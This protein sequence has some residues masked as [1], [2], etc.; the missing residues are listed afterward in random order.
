MIS[1]KT[2]QPIYDYTIQSTKVQHE[3]EKA[4]NTPGY[5]SAIF[6]VAK[7]ST[8]ILDILNNG[9]FMIV[10]ETN[11]KNGGGGGAV[12]MPSSSVKR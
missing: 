1:Y 11:T 10:S 3:Y 5:Q 8:D 9:L 7:W 6:E 2:S 12:T 4:D